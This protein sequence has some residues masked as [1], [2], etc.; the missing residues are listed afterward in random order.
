[1]PHKGKITATMREF[2]FRRGAKSEELQAKVQEALKD[3]YPGVSISV[4]KDAV[5]PPAGYAISIQLQGNDYDE[6]IKTAQ[7][8]RDYINAKS[9]AGIDELKIDVNKAKPAML[10]EVDRKKAG[11]LGIGT[12][13][14]GQQLR[15]AVFGAKAGIYKEDGEDYD[16][17]VRFNQDDKYKTSAIFEQ[18]ITSRDQAS[19]QIREIPISVVAKKKNNSGFSA[20]KHDKVKRVVLLYSALAPGG[21]ATAIV[22]QIQ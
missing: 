14:V 21:Y 5:G 6:L 20:I 4:E 16:I 17:Y 13:Q 18:R 1:M 22:N 3:V 15:N 7:R 8:M 11:E 12:M 10:V 2:K 9:I 19:G